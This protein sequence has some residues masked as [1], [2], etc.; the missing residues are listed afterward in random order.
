M[1]RFCPD[2]LDHED[3]GVAGRRQRGEDPYERIET[4]RRG[5]YDD[6]SAHST[7]PI[8]FAGAGLS[9]ASLMFQRRVGEPN[10]DVRFHALPLT[11]GRTGNHPERS[12][13]LRPNNVVEADFP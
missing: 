4:T 8:A 13:G 7:A 5:S 3:G 11:G 2:V 12:Y 9:A 10:D 1:L 6:D